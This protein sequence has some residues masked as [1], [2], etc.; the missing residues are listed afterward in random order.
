MPTYVSDG[1]MIVVMWYYSMLKTKLLH[2]V[3]PIIFGGYL[4]YEVPNSTLLFI[5]LLDEHF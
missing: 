4:T 3:V 1:P 2:Y 5:H